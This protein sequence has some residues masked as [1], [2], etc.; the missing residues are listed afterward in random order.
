MVFFLYG[1]LECDSAQMKFV[2]DA[3]TARTWTPAKS[4]ALSS[5]ECDWSADRV[6]V[7]E[8]ILKILIIVIR[9]VQWENDKPEE[10]AT[11][12]LAIIFSSSYWEFS[13]LSFFRVYD[14]AA[15]R[16]KESYQQ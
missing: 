2:I 7:I 9:H 1:R 16:H 8:H 15:I 6:H 3:R 11:G 12:R 4:P 5:A 10:Y 13:A 14:R